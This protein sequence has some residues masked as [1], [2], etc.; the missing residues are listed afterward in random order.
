MLH[1]RG[2]RPAPPTQPVTTRDSE[3]THGNV[4]MSLRVGVTTQ[5]EVLDTFGAPNITTIDGA[6]RE[7]WTYQRNATVAPSSPDRQRSA[8][9]SRPSPGL[10]SVPAAEK[11][12]V[13]EAG[14]VVGL[15]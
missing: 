8:A 5:A 2:L 15:L 10:T 11:I 4:Q 12:D 13:N 6:G 14:K 3:L 7:V 1:P 9:T